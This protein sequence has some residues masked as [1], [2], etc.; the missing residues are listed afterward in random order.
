MEIKKISLISLFLIF[1]SGVALAQNIPPGQGA[2]AEGARF[3]KETEQKIEG[4]QKKKAKAPEIPIEEKAA[5]AAPEGVAFVLKDVKISGVT[6]FKPEDFRPVYEPYI[7][8]KITY[9]DLSYLSDKIK[10]K[11]KE[12]GYLTTTAYLPE[13]EIKEG[14]VEI[15]VAEGKA[16]NIKIEG[17]KWTSS[18]LIE[19]YIHLKKNE[20]LNVNT[21][22]RDILRLNQGT[23][24][25]LYATLTKGEAPE[26]SD[27]TLKAVE[28]NPYHA[29][30]GFDNQG[31][32]LT[33]KDR[34]SLIL[35]S[36]NLTGNLDTIFINNL[37][38][39]NS[40]GESVNY[41]IPIGTNG[42][43]FGID[44][45]YF[46]MKIGKE[47]KPFDI[48]G[49][50]QIYSPHI[51]WELAL[52]ELFQA[53]LNL[54]MD[55]KS[56]I[57]KTGG[58]QSSDDQLRTPY[59]GF[60]FTQNDNFGQTSFSPRFDFGTSN[61]WGS[62]SRNHTSASRAGT[63]GDFFKYSQ[64]VGR[65]Q[66]MPFDSYISI[67]SQFQ[68]ASHTLPSSEQLQIGGANSVRGYPEGDYL[69]DNGGYVSADW[70]MP[71]FFIPKDWKLAGQPTV[72]RHQIEP[73]LFADIGGGG[74]KK[75][76]TGELK[77]KFLAG[78]GAGL[79]VHFSNKYSLRLD[80]AKH[81]GDRPT[82]GSG[83]SNFYITFQ[84]EV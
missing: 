32:R 11:Y 66:K 35:W 68:A 34:G 59:F 45:T 37:F 46:K 73:V 15:R 28:K 13:Q 77:D 2:G 78:I 14:V 56:I 12:K 6:L 27:I 8:K 10:A 75:V 49:V 76:E 71:M 83:P 31:T 40:L 38:S 52:D 63:G 53:N 23:D 81:V 29:V 62:S 72:L 58:T 4:L 64:Y 84:S 16:G 57:Q 3:K 60:N 21:L 42:T 7:G 67:R 30:V 61:F 9:K 80:W 19:K 1:L 24:L 50:T 5:P 54:G 47:F 79:R 43:K 82:A 33:G 41:A 20:L 74:L 55:I 22:Q 39:S 18:S 36:S 26:T 44:S 25:Q 69:S 70:V 65:I 51:S 17:N 48:T